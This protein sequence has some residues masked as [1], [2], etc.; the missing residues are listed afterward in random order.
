MSIIE[1]KIIKKPLHKPHLGFPISLASL[2]IL[3]G[4]FIRILLDLL[5]PRLADDID[6]EDLQLGLQLSLHLGIAPGDLR[7]NDLAVPLQ[8]DEKKL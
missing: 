6:L 1:P 8:V 5:D 2:C 7:P 4:G 3:L